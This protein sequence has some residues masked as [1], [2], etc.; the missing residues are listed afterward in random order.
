MK[1]YASAN[2]AEI[3]IDDIHDVLFYCWKNRLD[4]IYSWIE[5]IDAR[6]R[7]RSITHDS[8]WSNLHSA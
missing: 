2:A 5:R 4:A 7:K 8:Q 3:I 1:S 6:I